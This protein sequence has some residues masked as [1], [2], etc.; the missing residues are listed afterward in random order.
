MPIGFN[1]GMI[2]FREPAYLL[3]LVLPAALFL[4]WCWRALLRSGDARR[5]RHG[6]VVPVRE[7]LGG[8]GGLLFWLGVILSLALTVLALAQPTG[9]VVQLRSGGIDLIVLQDGSASMHVRDVAPDRW[10]RSVKFLRILAESLQWTDDRVALALFAHIAAAQVRL[11]R[12]PNTLFFFLEHLQ[13]ESPFPLKDDSTWDTNMELGVHWGLRLI[14][15]DEQLHGP[16]G[17]ARAFVLVS[18]GQAW[19]GEIQ[20]ALTAVRA[21]DIPVFVVGVGTPAG[22]VIPDPPEPGPR[23]PLALPPQRIHSSLDRSSLLA[24]AREG[25]GRYFDLDR[26]SDRSIAANII[27]ATRRRSRAQNGDVAVRELYWYCLAAAGLILCGSA[28]CL[29]DRRELWLHAPASAFALFLFW[30]WIQ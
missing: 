25:A 3:L 15:K 20:R 22:G 27:A 28:V 18:D 6:H 16:S 26:E 24:I 2:H 30:R 17:N 10:G 12:D 21:R 1:P 19:S 29:R 13:E 7:R 5:L 8:A 23:S 14:D 4:A 11:T 9:A